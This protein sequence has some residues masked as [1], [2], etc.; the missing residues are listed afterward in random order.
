MGYSF[1][2]INIR[3]IWFKLTQMMKDIPEDD[4]RQSYIVRLEPNPVL[5]ELDKA[6]GLRTI[7]LDPDCHATNAADRAHLLADFLFQ[8]GSLAS[9]E[10]TLPGRE[11]RMFASTYLRAALDPESPSSLDDP[12]IGR[13]PYRITRASTLA[14]D[15]AATRQVPQTLRAEYRVT[16]TNLIS[17]S[18][19]VSAAAKVAIMQKLLELEADPSSLTSPIAHLLLSG[20]SSRKALSG[21]SGLDWDAVWEGTLDDD[22]VYRINTSLASELNY[23]QA[24]NFDAD[25]FWAA[26]LGRRVIDG[27]LTDTESLL[28]VTRNLM[29]SAIQLY[30]QIGSYTPTPNPTDGLAHVLTA[31]E[32]K[33]AAMFEDQADE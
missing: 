10:G 29:S 2:D 28:Q 27:T 32:A 8:L 13:A 9:P 3:I 6:V 31:A 21:A 19:P 26:D 20:G 5:E 33:F 7:V 25:L 11:E 4:R 18:M 17:T 16:L 14:L 22:A 30:P 12:S 1:R 24:G 15:A 23:H